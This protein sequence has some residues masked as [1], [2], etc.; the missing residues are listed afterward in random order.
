MIYVLALPVIAFIGLIIFIVYNMMKS[1]A[2]KGE[3]L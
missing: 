3:E 1:A 2:E